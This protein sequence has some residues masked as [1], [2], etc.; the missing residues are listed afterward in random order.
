MQIANVGKHVWAI[1]EGYIP[2]DDP[3]KPRP[4][5]SHEAA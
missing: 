4:L 5:V 2:P 1:P 3:S